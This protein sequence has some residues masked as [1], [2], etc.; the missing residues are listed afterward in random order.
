[1]R[2]ELRV[3][4]IKPMEHLLTVSYWLNGHVWHRS[5]GSGFNSMRDSLFHLKVRLKLQNDMNEKGREIKTGTT[6]IIFQLPQ[7]QDVQI[8]FQIQF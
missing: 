2:T 4:L 8:E 6:G 1:M 5:L 7:V 3:K